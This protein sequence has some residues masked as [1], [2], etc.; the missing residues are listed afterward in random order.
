MRFFLNTIIFCLF[1]VTFLTAQVAVKEDPAYEEDYHAYFFKLFNTLRDDVKFDKSKIYNQKDSLEL[2]ISD[3]IR[4]HNYHSY[5]HQKSPHACQNRFYK[6]GYVNSDKETIIPFEYDWVQP[7]YDSFLLVRKANTAGIINSRG[8][9][10]TPLSNSVYDIHDN[11]LIAYKAIGLDSVII[12]YNTKGKFLFNVD[13]YWARRMSDDYVSIGGKN[14]KFK[15]I[16]NVNGK[17][18]ITPGFYDNVSWVSGD[19]FCV[20]KD[21]KYG[22][23]NSGNKVVL[24]FEYDNIAPA[25]K[26]QFIVFKDRM[27]GVVN[28]KNEVV[29]PFDSIYIENFGKLYAVRKRRS[30]LWGLINS[31]GER[32]LEEK[33]NINIPYDFKK[34]E[35]KKIDSQSCLPVRDPKTQLW[36]MFRSDGFRVLPIE[37]SYINNKPNCSSIIIGKKADILSDDFL[38]AAVD[39]NGKIL[40]PFS[41]NRLQF[42]DGSPGL[43]LST[44]TNGLAAFV[45]ART[46]E[47][48]TNYEFEGIEP[49]FPLDNGFVVAKKNWRYALVSPEGKLLTDI[50]YSGFSP[51]T[52]KNRLWFSEEII[53]LGRLEEKLCGITKT[54]KAIPI[55]EISK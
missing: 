22:I 34:E 39:I 31:K 33:Y 53:C 48:F 30:D 35:F 8:K 40:V 21:K 4:F 46:G 42:I 1:T 52:E 28:A 11:S 5:Y 25:D 17:W 51:A 49:L 24:P 55:K 45:N 38:F 6:Y 54:G 26:D 41:G 16:I 18:T 2:F 44:N 14:A 15:G 19:L 9:I 10:I 29:I 27:S 32:I 20:Y 36:G 50:V 12:F 47:I 7:R 13:G 23:I 3:S 43:L 37:Y